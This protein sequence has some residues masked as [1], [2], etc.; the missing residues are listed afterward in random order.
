MEEMSSFMQMIDGFQ[1][2]QSIPD[3]IVWKESKDDIFSVKSGFKI[4]SQSR[5]QE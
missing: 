3:R 2:Q 4:L 1:R 5:Q